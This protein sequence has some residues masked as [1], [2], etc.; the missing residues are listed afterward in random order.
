[1]RRRTHKA[2]GSEVI[3]SAEADE[4]QMAPIRSG[5]IQYIFFALVGTGLFSCGLVQ[6]FTAR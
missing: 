3:A 2:F 6:L 5:V 1:M 4:R